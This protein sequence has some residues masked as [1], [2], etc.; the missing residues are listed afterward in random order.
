[1][2]LSA[3]RTPRGVRQWLVGA[4]HVPP[5]RTAPLDRLVA[6]LESAR[7]APP[8]G[9]GADPQE[10]RA[11]VKAVARIVGEQVP[12]GR[13]RLSRLLPPSGLALLTGAASR[14]DAAMEGAGERAAGQVGHVG[15]EVRK[16]V[17][18]GRKR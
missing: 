14:A 15:Q 11:D 2:P 4:E 1:V 17:G 10:L 8:G 3:A 7:Y 12:A 9:K 18:T 5:D 13:R 16:L 6:E